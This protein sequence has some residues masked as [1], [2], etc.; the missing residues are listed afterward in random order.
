MKERLK[1]ESTRFN[2]V[3]QCTHRLE[4]ETER[5]YFKRLPTSFKLKAEQVDKLRD[6]AHRLLVNSEEYQ[7]FLSDLK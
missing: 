4:N 1:H 5:L 2:S 3:V 7:R 6:V